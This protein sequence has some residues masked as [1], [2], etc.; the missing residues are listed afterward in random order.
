MRVQLASLL[1]TLAPFLRASD[2][3]IAIACFLLF[4]VPPFPPI[5][6]RNAPC[7]RRRIALLTDFAALF[8]Y[9][10]IVSSPQLRLMRELR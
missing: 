7:L 4:T 9:L 3:P 2:S 8:P 1:G 6:E 5:P 10:A